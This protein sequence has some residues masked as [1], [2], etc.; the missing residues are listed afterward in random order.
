[1]NRRA[2]SPRIEID[3][4]MGETKCVEELCDENGRCWQ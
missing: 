4:F 3:P 2:T 1:M